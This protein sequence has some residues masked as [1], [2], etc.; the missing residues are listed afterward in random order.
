MDTALFVD[1]K[2]KMEERE[3]IDNAVFKIDEKFH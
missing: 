3:A 1:Y 2:K